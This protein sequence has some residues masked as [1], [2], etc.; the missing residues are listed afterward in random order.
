MALFD[1]IARLRL[2]G[3]G[4]QQGLNKAN[5]AANKFGDSVRNSIGKYFTAGFLLR[6]AQQFA[7]SILDQA[8]NAQRLAR[9]YGVSVTEAQKL[10]IVAKRT[11]QT[12]A[13]FVGNG[14]IL[15]ERLKEISGLQITVISKEQ[16][17][18][19]NKAS[20]AV[21][22]LK[23]KAQAATVDK[24]V[25]DASTPRSDLLVPRGPGKLGEFLARSF[26]L[27]RL[28]PKRGGGASG[29]WGGGPASS[30]DLL[31]QKAAEEEWANARLRLEMLVAR[32]MEAR[33][34]DKERELELEQTILKLR[35]QALDAEGGGH[36]LESIRL[37]TDATAM[38]IELE[39]LRRKNQDAG[40]AIGGGGARRG[41]GGSIYSDNL[42]SVGNFLG[43][44]DPLQRIGNL[45]G[46][47][48]DRD[49]GQGEQL[50]ALLRIARSVE[51]AEHK[52]GIF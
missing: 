20:A 32:Q 11:G 22:V 27:D 33:L 39:E 9:E 51:A 14:K 44:G 16:V 6:E 40:A 25:G 35:E 24:V 7:V 5:V 29:S 12:F 26:G 50:V 10:E 52:P 28:I 4:F 21:D 13:E 37:E 8:K 2:D 45:G 34:T 43:S 31:A 36:R 41:G 30:A 3:S 48:P 19:L 47:N 1:L 18:A 23:L 15:A 17:E 49:G 38:A 46:A 42:T